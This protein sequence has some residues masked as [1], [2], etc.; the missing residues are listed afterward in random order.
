MRERLWRTWVEAGTGLGLLAATLLVL[1]TW[2]PVGPVALLLVALAGAGVCRV[3]RTETPLPLQ[4]GLAAQVLAGVGAWLAVS[5]LLL[6]GVAPVLA[7]A[8]VGG[9]GLAVAAGRGDRRTSYAASAALLGLGG[10]SLVPGAG[11]WS[12]DEP[13]TG[14]PTA[15]MVVNNGIDVSVDTHGFLLQQGV[16]ILA[17]DGHT[18]LSGFLLSP[19][20]TAPYL[21][22]ADGTP[23]SRHES[24]LWRMQT[25]A[26]DADRSLKR[27]V[28][29]DHFFNWWTHAGKGM[30]AGTSAATW[31]EQQFAEAVAAWDAGDRARAAYHLGA[32]AHLVDDA[33]APPH[34]SPVVPNHRAFEDWVVAHQSSWAVTRGG[35]YRGDFRVHSGHGGSRWSSSHTRGWV[36]ECAHRG[37]EYIPN[38][39]QPPPD[40]LAQPGA[41]AGTRHLF[42]DAQRL[43]A[44]YLAFF[45]DSV[46]S[47][48]TGGVSP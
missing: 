48:P 11:A 13:R 30:I 27:T 29:P 42:Q 45:F 15:A 5:R 8:Y 12:V 31:A 3:L 19:D 47:P 21:R 44:G 2:V 28:M 24:Y 34:A 25:G 36:D 39:A 1:A 22:K 43:T 17:G 40:L 32:A 46:S 26:R 10:W 20:P 16:A 14:R 9:W 23:T 18:D 38:S 33:C 6:V 4:L 35:L 41:Y 37:V 7:A